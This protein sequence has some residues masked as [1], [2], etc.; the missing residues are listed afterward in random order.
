MLFRSDHL[1]HQLTGSL[2]MQ[3][4]PSLKQVLK[5]RYGRRLAGDSYTVTDTRLTWSISDY[6]LF[7]EAANLFDT[8]YVESGFAPMPGRWITAGVSFDWR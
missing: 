6:R 8:H 1:E 3:W 4:A 2:V 5:V 7:V